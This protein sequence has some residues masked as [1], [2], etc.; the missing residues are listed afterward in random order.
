MPS[1]P[2]YLFDDGEKGVR[3]LTDLRASFEVRVGPFTLIERFLDEALAPAG[4]FLWGVL[5]PGPMAGLVRER[6]GITV[7]ELR[8]GGVRE[9]VLLLNG[10]CA[11]PDWERLASLTPGSAMVEP[12]T[13]GLVAACVEEALATR[14][15][16][17][18]AGSLRVEPSEG[19]ALMSRP[20]HARR[21]RDRALEQGLDAA[22]R[23]GRFESVGWTEGRTVLGTAL[24]HAAAKIYPGVI[25]DAE[26][27]PVVIDEGAVI[28]PGAV[29]VG[30]CYVG[31]H[32]TVL[33]RATIRPNTVIGPWCKV[34]GEV[35]GTVFQGFANKA[36]EGFLGDSWVGEWVNLGAGTTNSNLLNTYG[37]VIARGLPDGPNERTGEQFLGAIIG[38]H[39]KTAICTRIMTGAVVHTGAMLAGS[40]PVSGPV[41]AFSWRTDE[42]VRGYRLSKFV[43]VARAAMA[44]RG[45][46][47]S[48]EYLA[49]L[50]RL[51]GSMEPRATP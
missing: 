24:A 40:A 14:V 51:H 23:T 27:G 11:A 15:L 31:P 13:G 16:A 8:S 4:F 42:G 44:R 32:S 48:A 35:S 3:P 7:N 47:P 36:H 43:E 50:Q 29:L 25:I 9:P 41:G 26:A 38:D 20:W 12:E 19:P 34:N 49:V 6:H 2:V 46:G 39:V 30:P 21:F 33:E 37:E 22:V 5:V 45:M 1:R 18:G 17:D 28:R 10:R